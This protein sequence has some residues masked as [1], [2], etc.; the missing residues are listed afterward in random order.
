MRL[1]PRF[2]HKLAIQ[3]SDRSAVYNEPE[4]EMAE[5]TE[6]AYYLIESVELAKWLEAQPNTWWFVDGDPTLTAEVDFPCPNDELA[7]FLRQRHQPLLV[8]DRTHDSPAHGE[9]ISAGDLERL[10]DQEN[11][12]GNRTFVMQWVGSDIPWLLSEDREASE[13]SGA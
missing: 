13:S 4:A 10:A 6:L 1:I 8:L 12:Y 7:A 9:R 5:L 3:L 11:R 2:G